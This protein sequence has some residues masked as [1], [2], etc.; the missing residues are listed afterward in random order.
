MLGVGSSKTCGDI[1]IVACVVVN[2]LVCER[3]CKTRPASRFGMIRR[4]VESLIKSYRYRNLFMSYHPQYEYQRS[5]V[6]LKILVLY[7]IDL[8]TASAKGKC[9]TGRKHSKIGH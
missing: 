4:F 3:G 7:I 2:V 1:P 9:S 5:D 6:S 8:S